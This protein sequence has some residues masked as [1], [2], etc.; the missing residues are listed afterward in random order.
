MNIVGVSSELFTMLVPTE[1][2]ETYLTLT[3]SKQCQ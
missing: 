1:D 3:K 2:Q